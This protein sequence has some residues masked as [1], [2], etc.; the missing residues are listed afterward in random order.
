VAGIV[1]T[2]LVEMRY[3]RVNAGEAVQIGSATP[4]ERSDE[5]SE[6]HR[7]PHVETYTEAQTPVD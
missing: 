4:D 5:D 7:A 1:F 2:V 6:E 3:V